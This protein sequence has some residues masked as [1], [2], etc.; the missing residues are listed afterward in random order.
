MLH[1]INTPSKKK[2]ELKSKKTFM[3]LP[4]DVREP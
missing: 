4:G 1:S 2:K 3:S